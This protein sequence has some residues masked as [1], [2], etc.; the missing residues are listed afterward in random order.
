MCWWHTCCLYYNNVCLYV[1]KVSGHNNPIQ[2]CSCTRKGFTPYVCIITA[3]NQYGRY[4]LVKWCYYM[5][6][7]GKVLSPTFVVGGSVICYECKSGINIHISIFI[8]VFLVLQA[9]LVVKVHTLV[10]Y[11]LPTVKFTSQRNT[12]KRSKCFHAC[13][14]LHMQPSTYAG[15]C[16]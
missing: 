5:S 10:L 3:I 16:V 2:E 15:I 9:Y 12:Y 8:F 6:L 14:H 7:P 1:G 11:V 4:G 13:R